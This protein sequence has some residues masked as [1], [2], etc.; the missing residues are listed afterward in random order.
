MDRDHIKH[1]VEQALDEFDDRSLGTCGRRAYRI[2]RLLG[3][4]EIAHR[5]ELELKPS[6]AAH[7]RVTAVQALYPDLS[8]EEV[9]ERHQ[10]ELE[11]FIES[12]TPR[13]LARLGDDEPAMHFGSI[14]ELAVM[15][16]QSKH[17]YERAEAEGLMDAVHDGAQ[18]LADRREIMDRI[19]A[20]VFDHLVQTET[21]LEVSDTVSHTLARHRSRVDALLETV[22]PELRDRLQAALRAAREGGGEARSQVLTTCRR[23]L[24]AVADHLFPA[25]KEPFVGD[26]GV[27]RV[28]GLGNYRNRILAACSG[29]GAGDRAFN[30]AMADLTTRLDRL[31][32]LAQKGVHGEVSQDEMEFGLAQTYLL[33]GELMRRHGV[34]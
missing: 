16:D 7:D 1:L 25:R 29:P 6:M 11:R 12:R 23:V 19:R 33:V 30:S 26:D 18:T 34:Q 14:D 3:N 15:Y 20:V 9:H 27:S 13:R 17:W 8:Y 28:V 21:Q 10:S 22:A 5:L 4:V 32:E 31:D 24:E 2:A